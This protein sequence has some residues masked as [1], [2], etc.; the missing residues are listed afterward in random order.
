MKERFFDVV[1]LGAGPGGY[2]AGIRA[3]Q[4]GLSAAVVEKDS[5]GGVCL[6]IGCIPSK[7]LIHQ[8][9]LFDEGKALLARVGAKVDVSGFEYSKVWQ[10]SRLA[11]D[12]L[13]KGVQ[14]LL[15]KNKVELVKG[16]GVLSDSNSIT[17]DIGGE[18]E[19]LH[20]KALILAT[21][22]RPRSLP[23]FQI[24]EKMVLSS[25]GLLMSESLPSSITILG[26]GA[27]GMEFAYVL[28]AFGADVTVVE[29]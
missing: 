20:G 2:V 3:A 6:N 16:F 7:S 27:I 19:I 23:G 28:R 4:L 13:S 29:L 11:A 14:F 18:K 15:K 24:D 10:S 22:S 26:A 5:P 8:A 9:S 17:V 1:I 12:R 21:G 25:T